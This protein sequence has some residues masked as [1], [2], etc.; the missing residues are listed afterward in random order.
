MS[1]LGVGESTETKISEEQF[2]QTFLTMEQ[3]LGELY[4]D[5]KARDAASSKTSKKEKGK[6][7]VD[8]PHS[9]S[10]SP[11]SSSS[12]SSSAEP[13]TEKKPKKTSL[14]KLDVKFE[15]PI[16]DGEMNPKKLDN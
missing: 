8:K 12:S 4:K 2:Q 10:S 6:G 14:L 7:K 15:L 5:K 11:S 3:M 9:P 1:G 13:K 16:Y